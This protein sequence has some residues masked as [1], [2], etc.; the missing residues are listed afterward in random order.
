MYTINNELVGTQ[1]KLV[2]CGAIDETAMTNGLLVSGPLCKY[3]TVE[4]DPLFSLPR[5]EQLVPQ[6]IRVIEVLKQE[7]G[8]MIKLLLK[9]RANRVYWQ[10]ELQQLGF[11]QDGDLYTLMLPHE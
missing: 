10:N 4:I 9:G 7:G 8:S 6:L 1:A 11:A 3:L 2:A 5:Q